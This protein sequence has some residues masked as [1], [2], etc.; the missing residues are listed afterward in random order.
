[1][2][3]LLASLWPGPAPAP[4]PAGEEE[5]VFSYWGDTPTEKAAAPAAPAV[6]IDV[7]DEARLAPRP[8]QRAG[9]RGLRGGLAVGADRGLAVA[10]HGV[11]PLGMC[12]DFSHFAH[13]YFSNFS[14][15]TPVFFAMRERARA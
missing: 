7:Y 15:C 13:L 10:E 3:S 12:R 9:S 8:V 2:D 11:V 1:M 4:A 6:D 5:R 14:C